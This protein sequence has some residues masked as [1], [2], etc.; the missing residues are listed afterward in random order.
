MKVLGFM[1]IHY[2]KEYL[3]ASLKS[4]VDECEKVLIAYT[5][6]PSHGFSS[7]NYCPDSKDDIYNICV[8]VLGS[9]LI[10]SENTYNAENKHREAVMDYASDYD[11]V[12]SVDADEVYEPKELRSALEYAYNNK[13]RYYGLKGYINFWRCFDFACFDGFRPVRIENLRN[14]NTE[15]NLECPLTVYHFSTAQSEPVMRYKYSIFGHAPEVRDGWLDNVHYGWRRD[16][17][18]KNL[19]CVANDIWNAEPFDKNTLP[20]ILKQ[21]PNFNKEYI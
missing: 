15:Q 10:W 11:L 17:E 2:G 16:N 8:S 14:N 1:P 7:I 19:H 18:L 13:Q 3:E 5:P 4:I 21:H 20:D 12:L 6:N 9:K